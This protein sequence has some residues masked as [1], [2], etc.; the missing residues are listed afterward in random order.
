M[1]TRGEKNFIKM[2]LFAAR[3]YDRLTDIKGVNSSFTKMAG[4]VAAR[5]TEGRLLDVGTGPGRL[6]L[7]LKEQI[8]GM[9][10]HG[11][12]ISASMLKIAA[13]KLKGQAVL[14]EGNITKTDYPDDY[15]D[16]VVCSG[17]FYNWDAP[18]DGLNEIYRI[19]KPGQ[20]AYL[21]ETTRDYDPD[22]LNINM[23]NN[24]A[25]Y[26]QLRRFMSIM[27][28]KKQLKMTYSTAEYNQLVLQSKFRDSYSIVRDVLGNLPIYV[29]IEL[30][31]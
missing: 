22:L 29:R 20:K 10:L 23:Q 8:P 27:F 7:E 28:L 2:P 9:E 1:E 5:F 25:G 15:F 13:E 14:N 21:F 17:S 24:L 3:K 6:L 11:L 12:D 4:Y 26:G 16:C 31:K 19:L 18:I 30:T